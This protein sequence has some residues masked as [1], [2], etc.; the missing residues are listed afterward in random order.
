MLTAVIALGAATNVNVKYA[1]C[2]FA[3][4]SSKSFWIL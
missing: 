2:E 1:D 4:Y 3:K